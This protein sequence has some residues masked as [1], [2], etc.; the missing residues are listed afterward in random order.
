[1]SIF[2]PEFSTLFTSQTLELWTLWKE[3]ACHWTAQDLLQYSPNNKTELL[4]Q[5]NTIQTTA[6]G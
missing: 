1:M 6:K 5:I 2:N 3:A 4:M